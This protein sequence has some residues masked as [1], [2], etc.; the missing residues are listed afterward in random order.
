MVVGLKSNTPYVIKASPEV[1]INGTW[2]ANELDGCLSL[3]GEN[4]FRVR[5]VVTDN[6]SS[7]VNAFSVLKNHKSDDYNIR[8]HANHGK[9][10]FCITITS[11][12]SK[13]SVFNEDKQSR[14]RNR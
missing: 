10:L 8:H 7:N 14:S 13:T 6:H 5:A 11:I 1:S 9:T 12:P 4:G 2:L 3:L